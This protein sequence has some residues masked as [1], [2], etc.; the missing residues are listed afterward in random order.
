M[1]EIDQT[2]RSLNEWSDWANVNRDVYSAASAAVIGER[3]LARGFIEPL[4]NTRVASNEITSKSR[5]W[6][7]SLA[8]H[9]LNSR[10]R[11]VLNLIDRKT[12]DIPR[13]KTTIFATEAITPFALRLRGIFPKFL[14]SEYGVD[15]ASREAFWPIQHQDLTAL[16]LPSD[17]FEIVTTNEVL[18]HVPDLDAAL[19]EIARILKPGGWHIGTH[20]FLF[21]R[22][23]GDLRAKI[24][25]GKIVHLKE[26]PEFHGNPVDPSGGSLVFETPGWDIIERA[27]DAGFNDAHMRFVASETHG[28]ISENTGIFVLCCR[29]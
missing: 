20:P 9:G 17:S 25:A 2:F 19:R 16:S 13:H 26:P 23:T 6:R 11:A 5:N 8:A 3:I 15:E 14:G 24:V 4:T 22:P 28:Y 7:E 1:L 27:R 12:R 21:T 29:K 18:E 10:A